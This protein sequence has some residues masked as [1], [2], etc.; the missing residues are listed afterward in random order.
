MYDLVLKLGTVWGNLS[1]LATLI[2]LAIIGAVAGFLI[3]LVID[4]VVRRR[5]RKLFDAICDFE[6]KE[7]KIPKK[8]VVTKKKV[9]KR[10][11]IKK[12]KKVMK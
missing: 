8:K 12:K 6:Y 10:K 7:Q 3:S 5:H 11:V 4:A 1:P 2:V 9:T